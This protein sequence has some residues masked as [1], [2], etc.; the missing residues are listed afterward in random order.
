MRFTAYPPRLVRWSIPSTALALIPLLLPRSLPWCRL[1][2]MAPHI[3]RSL[4]QSVDLCQSMLD[5]LA[6]TPS[7]EPVRFAPAELVAETSE[8]ASIPIRYLG[9]DEVRIY[10][11]F[12]H[13][14]C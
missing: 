6:E 5:Y 10:R 4:E 2:R 12:Y 14:F 1:R 11:P 7:P 9:P 8:S 13:A 3:V